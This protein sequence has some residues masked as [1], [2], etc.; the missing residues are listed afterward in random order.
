MNDLFQNKQAQKEFFNNFWEKEYYLFKN[1]LSVDK[2]SID[3]SDLEDMATDDYFETRF[4]TKNNNK[5]ILE[6]S[7]ETIEK[8]RALK[9]EWTLIIHNLNLYND[10]CHK[11]EK[12]VS[13]IPQ[14]LFDDV[15]CTFSSDGSSLGAHIDRYNVFILQLSGKR[16]WELELN[17]INEYRDDCDIRVLKEFK[18][19]IEHDLSPGDMI[20][21]PPGVAHRGTSIGESLSLSIGFQS[22]EQKDI[23]EKFLQE[24]SQEYTQSYVTNDSEL[25]SEYHCANEHFVNN[26]HKSLL[27]KMQDNTLFKKT[28]FSHLSLNKV[29]SP[30]EN[31]I[32][33]NLKNISLQLVSNSLRI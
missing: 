31:P 12:L 23:I 30:I 1:C 32:S 10:F 29:D 18:T 13:F 25:E 17:P 21:I 4:I 20:Y 28:L 8:M 7:P 15:M 16:K 11:L 14:W 2:S 22:I 5:L 33:M 6:K 27:E 9:R 24:I 26:L 19:D 3:L